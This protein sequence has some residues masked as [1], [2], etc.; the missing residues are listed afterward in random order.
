[1][2][3]TSLQKLS[4]DYAYGVYQFQNNGDA[5][6]SLRDSAT[7]ALDGVDDTGPSAEFGGRYGPGVK[8]S[9]SNTLLASLNYDWEQ[10]GLI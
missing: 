2:N 1:M 6:S 9:F 8:L 3:D 5:N 10:I 7:T 4:G